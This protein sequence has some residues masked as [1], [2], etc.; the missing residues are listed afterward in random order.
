MDDPWRP[1]LILAVI[2]L[3]KQAGEYLLR[4]SPGIRNVWPGHKQRRELVD[5]LAAGTIYRL[6]SGTYKLLQNEPGVSEYIKTSSS[7]VRWSDGDYYLMRPTETVTVHRN[8]V[9]F[10]LESGSFRIAPWPSSLADR[11]SEYQGYLS[12]P[13]WRVIRESA[14]VNAGRRCQVCNSPK[15]LHVHHR[16]YENI[17]H[18]D[19]SDLTVLCK[20]CHALFHQGG[21][22]NKRK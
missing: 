22:I 14:L 4:F 11:E 7:W 3:L 16:T 12:S 13:A 17:F 8:R 10:S 2:M 18:E 21:R 6:P 20:E 9:Q 15:A 5:G 19:V 1:F